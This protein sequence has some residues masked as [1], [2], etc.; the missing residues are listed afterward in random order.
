MIHTE[1]DMQEI[2]EISLLQ[3]LFKGTAALKLR[4]AGISQISHEN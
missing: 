1:R 3:L 2:A 4:V